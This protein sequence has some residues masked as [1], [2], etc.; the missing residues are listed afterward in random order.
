MSFRNVIS[1]TALTNVQSYLA[2]YTQDETESYVRSG[3]LY[4][5]EIPFL[6]RVFDPTNVRSRSE[7]GGYKVVSVVHPLCLVQAPT[8]LQ[9]R[10]GIFQHQMIVDT[11]LVY[12]GRQGTKAS[13]PTASVPGED[14][15]GVLALVCTAVGTHRN[16]PRLISTLMLVSTDRACTIHALL[17]IF[18]QGLRFLL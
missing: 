15:I 3:F 8:F 1:T 18:C 13:I 10:H 4:Y 16:F 7:K 17:G 9:V 6:Y 14:P 2:R 5:G 12:Y 11:M